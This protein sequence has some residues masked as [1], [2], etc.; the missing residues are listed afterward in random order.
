[1]HPFSHKFT[2]I[3]ECQRW[4]LI[5]WWRHQAPSKT[6]EIQRWEHQLASSG[7]QQVQAL[8][9]PHTNYYSKE[10]SKAWLFRLQVLQTTGNR[11]TMGERRVSQVCGNQVHVWRLWRSTSTVRHSVLPAV[12]HPERLLKWTVECIYPWTVCS[13][14]MDPRLR[15]CC[16]SLLDY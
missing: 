1:M 13:V 5:C 15:H 6:G 14:T 16:I 7:V 10:E 2:N 4:I 3:Q 8:A 12:P 9:S 11:Q